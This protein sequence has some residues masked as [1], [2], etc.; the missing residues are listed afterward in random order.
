MFFHIRGV[1]AHTIFY[2]FL[3]SFSV[4]NNPPGKDLSVSDCE[5]IIVALLV[6]GLIDVS[7]L[8]TAYE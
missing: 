5:R 2:F 4:K 1:H 3:S 7:L 8:W 6:A